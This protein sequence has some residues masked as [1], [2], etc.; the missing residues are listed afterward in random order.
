MYVAL[1]LTPG[2]DFIP[3]AIYQY[4]SDDGAKRHDAFGFFFG[5]NNRGLSSN[6]VM[7]APGDSGGPTFENGELEAITSYGITLV[8]TNGQTSD[9]TKVFRQPILDSSCGEFAGDTRVSQYTTFI[10]SVLDNP[11]GSNDSDGDGFDDVNLGGNDCDDTDANIHPGAA[12]TAYDGIDSNCDGLDPDDVD[13]DG[14]AADQAVG[15]TPDCNDTDDTVFPG[16]PELEDGKD[17]DCDGQIDEDFALFCDDMTMDDLLNSGLYTNTIDNR[18]GS[19]AT[20]TGSD[21]PD[22][23]IAGD[24]GDTIFGQGGNDCLIGGSNDDSIYGSAGGDQIFGLGGNDLLNGNGRGDIIY[25]GAGND[26][27][28]GNKGNDSLIGDVGNDILDG[29][30]GTD[31]CASDIEDT[32]APIS[33]EL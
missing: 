8:F 22:L 23:I 5:I 11:T 29:G 32:T 17:N 10:E 13:L 26:T 27:I 16:A 12:E 4:D 28:N 20:L 15:G 25:G 24:F 2:V 3:G 1:G 19:S 30:S 33:C 14:S 18:G 21:G 7:S 6:E 31:T 9:C